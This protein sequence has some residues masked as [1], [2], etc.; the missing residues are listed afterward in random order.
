MQ[1][2]DL[3]WGQ[4]LVKNIPVPAVFPLSTQNQNQKTK[5]KSTRLTMDD[6]G[7]GVTATVI[8]L[9]LARMDAGDGT[10]GKQVHWTP[11]D[12]EVLLGEG[13][14]MLTGDLCNFHSSFFVALY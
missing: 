7:H 12:E 10:G 2:R 1:H 8:D 9:G 14:L 6:P 5:P 4:I 11:V 13:V 3:H